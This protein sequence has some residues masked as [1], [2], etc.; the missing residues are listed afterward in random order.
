LLS[1]E[2]HCIFIFAIPPLGFRSF[3]FSVP[4]SPPSPSRSNKTLLLSQPANT[5]PSQKTKPKQKKQSKARKKKKKKNQKRSNAK[6]KQEEEL[7]HKLFSHT[8]DPKKR[9]NGVQTW[10]KKQ[11]QKLRT[12]RRRQKQAT[13]GETTQKLNKQ[14][15]DPPPQIIKKTI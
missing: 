15:R 8:K 12:G 3:T 7:T 6:T 14:E 9:N 13:K 4:S 2:S 11:K 1:Q 10:S 5:R